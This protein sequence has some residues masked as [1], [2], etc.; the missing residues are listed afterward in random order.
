MIDNNTLMPRFFLLLI[1]I[2]SAVAQG[3][4]NKNIIDDPNISAKNL[5]ALKSKI[6]KLS[7]HIS[8]TQNKKGSIEKAL[9]DSE[10]QI[11][12][13][14]KDIH[15]IHQE[16]TVRFHQVKILKEK[17]QSLSQSLAEQQTY[18]K[19][20]IR[21]AYSMGKQ[22]VL[23]V[24]LN[25]NDPQKL[26]RILTYH[27][28]FSEARTKEI[29]KYRHTITELAQIRQKITR[30]NLK[31]V[32]NRNN[33]LKKRRQLKTSQLN[34]K[35]V[36]IQLANSLK[37]QTDKLA[38]YNAD[39]SQLEKLLK[40]VEKAIVDLSLPNE[41]RPF[42]QLRGKLLLPVKGLIIQH[43]GSPTVG[44]KIR[45]KGIF[46]QT[47]PNTEV[48]AVYYGRVVFSDWIR[49]YGLITIIDHGGGYM[50]L[51]GHNQSLLKE[52]GDWVHT[53]ETIALTGSS[54]GYGKTGL[55]FEL[56]KNGRARNPTGWFKRSRR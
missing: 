45:S 15:R 39:R 46:I 7:H 30:Q 43:Y 4:P 37:T 5:E 48:H 20:Q 12:K 16:L 56:R 54:G 36:L 40:D 9:K 41:N 6:A 35:R 18:L 23:K 38:K 11:S 21:I 17:E 8:T 52:T 34:R 44:G 25:Q 51:Y 32:I 2:I 33:L 47:R 53:G 13:I 31:L 1:L 3:A 42:H 24:L 10:Q 50:T 22:P 26:S 55:Y 14:S 49:G 27:S 28:Y 29:K 19:Q